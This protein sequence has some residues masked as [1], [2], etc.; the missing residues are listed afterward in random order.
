MEIVGSFFRR[1]S[2]SVS[3][4][5]R[6]NA[7]DYKSTKYFKSQDLSRSQFDTSLILELKWWPDE[8]VAFL[9]VLERGYI[10]FISC[11]ESS[12]SFDEPLRNVIFYMMQKTYSKYPDI[13]RF[14]RHNDHSI[15]DR[16]V[17]VMV[18]EDNC[19]MYDLEVRERSKNEQKHY[20]LV[21]ALTEILQYTPIHH[22]RYKLEAKQETAL[23]GYL[24]I[25]TTRKC[26]A[27]VDDLLR[28]ILH[29]VMRESHP[30]I[31][32]LDI[33][34]DLASEFQEMINKQIRY[35]D[36]KLF[37]KVFILQD[38]LNYAIRRIKQCNA[39][40]NGTVLAGEDSPSVM[41]VYKY[42]KDVALNH[43]KKVMMSETS[44]VSLKIPAEPKR[45]RELRMP[46]PRYFLSDT[47]SSTPRETTP[48]GSEEKTKT[49]DLENK[50]KEPIT[51]ESA[52][53]ISLESPTPKSVTSPRQHQR[54]VTADFVLQKRFSD[55]QEI[56]GNK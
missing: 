47:K 30:I 12:D 9:D 38:L 11:F 50:S 29:S 23:R 54:K 21:K 37:N 19:R 15:P 34:E 18:A 5:P 16:Y 51:S 31:D 35:I 25:Y 40:F 7:P 10:D 39:V 53:V 46:T 36:E 14:V 42:F 27:A 20:L 48:R 55:P 41:Y 45:D 3:G 26:Y 1:R 32:L 22:D 52:F 6:D 49:L 4:S 24:I 17:S 28:S 33:L 43:N 13:G 56:I 44:V 2:G 8:I